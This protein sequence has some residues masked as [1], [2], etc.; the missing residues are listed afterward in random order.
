MYIFIHLLGY[1]S[2]VLNNGV[3]HKYIFATVEWLKM[4]IK[5]KLF[6]QNN[7]LFPLLRFSLVFYIPPS[8]TQY[9]PF[10]FSVTKTLFIPLILLLLLF[11]FTFIFYKS[12]LLTLPLP[13][14]YC[15]GE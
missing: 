13:S 4:C 12:V 11:F 2:S 6:H 3:V 14:N 15:A 1:F 8:S 10:L 7:S 9:L 5:E